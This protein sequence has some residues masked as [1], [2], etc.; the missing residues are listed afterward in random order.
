MRKS[1]RGLKK[2]T[3]PLAGC[4]LAAVV[5]L[6]GPARAQE[7]AAF[8]KHNCSSCHTI[9]GGRLT[10]PDLKDVTKERD[11]EWFITFILNPK[12]V[13]DGGDDYAKRLADDSKGVVMPT[14][15]GMTRQKAEALLDLIEEESKKERSAFAGV[16]ISDQ[17][18]T[19]ADV[20][21][22]RDIFMGYARLQSGGPACISCHSANGAGT[23]GG[24]RLGPDL[25]RIFGQHGRKGLAAWLSAPATPTMQPVFM[26]TPLTADEIL[27]LVAYFEH[28]A[29]EGQPGGAA[30][31]LNFFLLGLGGAAGGLVAFD[32]VWRR[33]LRGVR[34]P[35]VH[36]E[37]P[38]RGSD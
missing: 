33:R 27:P 15:F 34:R 38:R 23:L 32:A 10:G 37:D 8:F 21:M 30:A 1:G 7:T 26:A 12:Q 5:F 9:G 16:Q 28:T 31:P 36:P 6:P 35:L 18:F 24:G 4:I 13:I 2:A 22:G 19:Q 20:D 29:K 25:T 14:I 11:R 3:V 17:P